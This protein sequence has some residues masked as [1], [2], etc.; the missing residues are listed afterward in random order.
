LKQNSKFEN[1]SNEI[2]VSCPF[3]CVIVSIEMG[4]IVVLGSVTSQLFSTMF[5]SSDAFVIKLLHISP[6]LVL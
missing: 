6:Y 5:P 4:S 3:I 2:G 1:L